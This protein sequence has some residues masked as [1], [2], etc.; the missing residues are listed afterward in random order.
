MLTGKRPY[1]NTLRDFIV[2]L[3]VVEGKKPSRPPSGFSDNLWNLL[4]EVWDPEYGSQPSR[5]PSIPSI[6]DQMRED[7]EGWDQS[8]IL[9]QPLQVEEETARVVPR[10]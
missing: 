8:L 10:V 6:L 5:R 7:A 9:G 1:D 3:E 4:L 2:M